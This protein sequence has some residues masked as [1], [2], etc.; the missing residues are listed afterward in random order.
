MFGL[1]A[2]RSRLTGSAGAVVGDRAG[3]CED[4]RQKRKHRKR[5]DSDRLSN[6]SKQRFKPVEL[7]GDESRDDEC[8]AEEVVELKLVLD[9][10]LGNYVGV[11]PLR[12]RK[13]R[14]MNRFR[15]LRGMSG[16]EKKEDE[17]EEQEEQRRVPRFK[18]A[19]NP[20]AA[21]TAPRLPLADRY[22]L[23]TTIS[24]MT[25]LSFHLPAGV[26]RGRHM[27]SFLASHRM[28][29]QEPTARHRTKEV[30]WHGRKEG[31][32]RWDG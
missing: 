6:Q 7:R 32:S 3:D 31:G 19:Q 17:K 27:P 23:L 8:R 21:L 25:V 18:A 4:E 9:G 16:I 13:R 29:A 24:S 30:L 14:P 15:Q 11:K 2:K 10:I 26:P 20:S 12:D 22:N 1:L 5:W 28:G